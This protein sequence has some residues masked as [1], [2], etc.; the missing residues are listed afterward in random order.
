MAGKIVSSVF[1]IHGE[2]SVAKARDDLVPTHYVNPCYLKML[3]HNVL[4]GS[5]LLCLAQVFSSS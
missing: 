1:L 2:K 5:K 3:S 4:E